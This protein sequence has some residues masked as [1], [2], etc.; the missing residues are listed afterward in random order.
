MKI[1]IIKPSSLGDIIL[2]IPVVSAL[3]QSYPDAYISWLVNSSFRE[4]ITLV[5]GVDEIIDFDRGG[6]K[7]I[8]LLFNNLKKLFELSKK[9]RK[10]KFD[11]IFDL[12]GLFRSGY[13]S[14]ISG[15]RRRIGFD[16]AREFASFFYTETVPVKGKKIHAVDANMKMVEYFTGMDGKSAPAEINFG[17][18]VPERLPE[19]LINSEYCVFCPSTRWQSKKWPQDYYLKLA[20]IINSKGLKV[21][22]TGDM[23]D[24]VF[25]EKHQH[26]GI[27]SLCGKTSLTSLAGVIAKAE[28]VVTNDSGPMH[29]AVAL[30]RKVYAIMGPTDPGKT[31]PYRNAE[32]ITANLECSPCFKR[33]CPRTDIPLE[34]LITISPEEVI[35]RISNRIT[36]P[37]FPES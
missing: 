36:K 17:L 7:N 31:G 15:A 3:K 13:F 1:L 8:Y 25:W 28:Y 14:W 10:K 6:W 20:E 27:I 26:D 16:N 34:C 19:K 35:K 4:L 11:I 32:I 9:I 18:S 23:S 29:L 24:A 33:Q 22:I 12:Q 5:H 21:V 30:G 37:L 2:A